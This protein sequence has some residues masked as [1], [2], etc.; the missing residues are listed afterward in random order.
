MQ[1]LMAQKALI[2]NS[3]LPTF[4][5]AERRDIDSILRCSAPLKPVFL[6]IFYKY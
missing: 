1:S 3:I 2:E 4:E 5:G 6:L